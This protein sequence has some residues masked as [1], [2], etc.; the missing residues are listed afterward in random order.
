MNIAAYV[1]PL[2]LVG[3]TRARLQ[4]FRPGPAFGLGYA[5]AIGGVVTL[6]LY[7]ASDGL[8]R[9]LA[10]VGASGL[11]LVALLAGPT[12]YAPRSVVPW[13]WL[14]L[15]MGAFLL[16]NA[17]RLGFRANGAELLGW[18]AD[19]GFIGYLFLAIGLMQFIRVRRPRYR[20]ARLVDGLAIG[21]V[22]V[23]ITSAQSL[24]DAAVGLDVAKILGALV[25]P[26]FETLLL[27]GTAYLV[28]AGGGIRGRA[29]QLLLL[30][31][32]LSVLA[33][34]MYGSGLSPS[35]TGGVVMNMLWMAGYLVIGLTALVP[36]MTGL[37]DLQLEEPQRAAS[38]SLVGL[39]VAV[40]ALT[41]INIQAS[42]G[43]T[44]YSLM[45]V[46]EGLLLL[47]VLYRA[48]ESA[49]DDAA[50]ERRTA[51][52]LANASDALAVVD[53]AGRITLANPAAERLI[54]IPASLAVGRP[55]SAFFDRVHPDER[56]V[57]ADRL[58]RVVVTP[59][60]TDMAQVRI[61]GAA[62]DYRSI[63]ITASNRL[64]D[65]AVA[66]VVLNMHDLT[67]QVRI[68]A[69]LHR[70][71]TAIE[72]ASDAVIVTDVSGT[73]EWVN[74]AFEQVTGYSRAEVV[75]RNPRMLKS[76]EQSAA[77]Y[78]S[79]WKTLTAG[80]PWRADF[81]NRRR[82]GR[83][84]RMVGV[85]TPLH[86]EAGTLT[87]YVSVQR[88]VTR[89]R[90]LE[91][92]TRQLS[93]E[94]ALIAN[95]VRA[96]DAHDEPEAI[97]QSVCDQLATMS[98][99]TH[100]AVFVFDARD[101]AI[102]YG[103]ALASGDPGPRRQIP[104]GRAAYLRD[105]AGRGPWIEAWSGRP[106][107]PYDDL[108]NQLGTRAHAYA[109]VRD[110]N[111]V[112]GVLV[113]GSA[114]ENAEEHLAAL[115]PTIVECADIC[116]KLVGVTVAARHKDSA[117]RSHIA[118]VIDKAE[119]SPVYQA[120][121]DTASNKIVGYEALTRFTDGT[122]PEVRFAEAHSV[123]LGEKLELAAISAALTGAELLPSYLWLNINASP[124]LVMDGGHLQRL[125]DRCTREVVLEVT[126]HAE[127]TDYQA[128]REAV[129]GLGPRVRLAVDDAG[130]GY[131]G[132]RHIVELRPWFVKLDREVISGVDHDEARQAM[133]AGMH[134]FARTTGCW[135]IAEGV[136]TKAELERLKSLDI[137]YIQGYLFGQPVAAQ[138]LVEDSSRWLT[139][140]PP[141]VA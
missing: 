49:R 133:V 28:F 122:P 27:G 139:T 101:V 6:G 118:R 65:E 34:I 60:T 120:L 55:I 107:H 47:L 68:G 121:I 18:L 59:G 16:G 14:A 88:D 50:R 116:G 32:G 15:A 110:G 69:D 79:M 128:F 108:L 9:D 111:N 11:G 102:P 24:Q 29:Q 134:H 57:M 61:Q 62:G 2:A 10:F 3:R 86:D 56:Q 77:Y 73:I 84:Y 130:A 83:L 127:I 53:G 140:D 52:L 51:M 38:R 96:I 67:D 136:E 94:R 103:F 45:E 105:H 64:A 58:E 5:Y 81:V 131:S 39:V 95:T 124:S 12:V 42:V 63:A 7:V 71:G 30:G 92:E 72:Q 33:D 85:I 112:I 87:G 90:A 36:S 117:E 114:T 93:R 125:L 109:P 22:A 41:A 31:V 1:E 8:L 43:A 126:E 44:G 98:D 23:V 46:V 82:D 75:G 20:I 19:V 78:E 132:L 74:P 76:G 115:L 4:A 80:R 48:R 66:G 129:Q 119:F 13:R 21:A 137:R 141:L 91:D 113:V 17:C 89:Q 104:R 25:T 40:V 35:A 135:L 99:I 70:L 37:T 138:K 26:T 54:G 100:A 123:G 106:G 97:A